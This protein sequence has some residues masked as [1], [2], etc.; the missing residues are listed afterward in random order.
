MP[1]PLA[2]LDVL[3]VE[4]EALI[5]M[6]IV[7]IVEDGGHRVVAEAECLQDV[8]ALATDL[9][10]DIAFVDVHLAR[11]TSGVDVCRL[12]LSRWPEAVV[13]F[14]TANPGKLPDDFAGGHGVISKP[15]TTAGFTSAISYLEEGMRRPPPVSAR[16]KSFHEAPAFAARWTN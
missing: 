16:P 4:D 12:L 10:I 13:V 7:G 2:P 15:F 14:V 9:S 6:D 3:V 8:A 1:V 11:R 5:A